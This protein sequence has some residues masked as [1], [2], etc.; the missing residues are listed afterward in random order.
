MQRIFMK[1]K[2][3]SVASLD[4]PHKE[5]FC[6]AVKNNS[7]SPCLL[8]PLINTVTTMTKENTGQNWI[9]KYIDN[10]QLIIGSLQLSLWL[11]AGGQ[12]LPLL[13][14]MW[15]TARSLM[16]ASLGWMSRNGLFPTPIDT[17][18]FRRSSDRQG[19]QT[20]SQTDRWTVR[21][22]DSLTHSQSVRDTDSW[23]KRDSKLDTE[24]QTDTMTS[25]STFV[26]GGL[27]PQ[28]SGNVSSP[29]AFDSLCSSL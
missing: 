29:C 12:L 5:I 11:A 24:S 16:A 25:L 27:G 17:I 1:K 20:V 15:C 13:F 14:T 9:L 4:K 18:S 21:Q 10:T 26:P 2:H 6:V 23:T 19:R 7:W 28:D 22:T 3:W 8:L